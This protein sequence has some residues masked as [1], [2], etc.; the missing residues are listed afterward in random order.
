MER[1]GFKRMERNG[2]R[3]GKKILKEWNGIEQRAEQNI[4]ERTERNEDRNKIFFEER[5]GTKIRTKLF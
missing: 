5:N 1:N 3:T 2:T 4:F